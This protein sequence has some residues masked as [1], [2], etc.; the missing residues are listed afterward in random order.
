MMRRHL[1]ACLASVCFYVSFYVCA[2]TCDDDI[3]ACYCPSHTP[4]GRVPAKQDAPLGECTAFTSDAALYRHT[5]RDQARPP[6][7]AGR[8]ATMG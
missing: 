5:I 3:A 6:S 7:K 1:G 8:Q 4:Y 2:G